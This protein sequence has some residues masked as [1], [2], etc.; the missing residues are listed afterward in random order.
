MESK[1]R[2]IL[3]G[4]F[5]VGLLILTGLFVL[6]LGKD[7]I[8]RTPYTIAT[9]MKVSGLNDQA[10][11]RYKGLKVGKVTDITFDEKNAGQLLVSLDIVSDTPITQSTYA[12]LGYQGV[13]GIA[14][15]ELD[16]DGSNTA[17][18]IVDKKLGA[19]I[20]LRPGLLQKLEDRGMA[21]LEQTEELSKRLNLLLDKNNQASLINT[22]AQMGKT[23]KAWETVPQQLEQSLSSLQPVIKQ[24]NKSFVSFQAFSD[25][26]KKTSSNF[27]QLIDTLQK[28]DGAIAQVSQSVTQISQQL[29]TETL[30]NINAL[31]QDARIALRSIERTSNQLGEQPQSILFG[32]KSMPPGPG[33][34]GFSPD[35]SKK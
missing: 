12:T 2:A 31:S 33:E 15:I 27:N 10:T 5:S 26:A 19:R 7:E 28:S 29:Q 3:A 23:A 8:I 30:P 22:V 32:K 35:T 6:W 16:D 9:T 24:A 21:I 20:P 4:I 18:I 1:S 25:D 34:A 13:T 14:Y 17:P 11:V